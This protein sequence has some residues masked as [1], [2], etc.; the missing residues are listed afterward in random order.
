MTQEEQDAVLGRTRR[1]Y[2][3]ARHRFGALRKVNSEIAAVARNL[4]DAIEHNPDQ[5]FI[6]NLPKGSLAIAITDAKYI[7]TPEAASRLSPESL[8]AQLD[9]Y[10]KVKNQK[11]KLRQEL[12]EQGDD[13]PEK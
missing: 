4:A 12:I 1:E 3:E 7:Y 11:A 5:L 8:V 10:M 6:G 13:D 9:E 2:R